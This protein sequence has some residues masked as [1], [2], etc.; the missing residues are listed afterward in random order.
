M[1]NS[2]RSLIIPLGAVAI[3]IALSACPW[4]RWSGGRLKD[5]H[6]F[7]DLMPQKMNADAERSNAADNV[8]PELLK[9]VEQGDSAEA[10][11]TVIEAETATA[12]V[13]IVPDVAPR[14][15]DVVLIEDYS[16]DGSALHKLKNTLAQ[17][18]I[19]PVRIAMVGDS[20]IEGDILAQD[21]RAGLQ[22]QYGGRGVGYVAAFSNFPGFRGSVNQSAKG[23]KETE[24]RKMNND[25]LR[26]ILG[27]YHTADAGAVSSF[28][29]SKRPDHLD[30][31][32]SSTMIYQ[33]SNP[34]SVTITVADS[35]MTFPIAASTRLQAIA[36]PGAT[37]EFKVEINSPGLDVLGIWLENSTGIVLD[38]ISLRGN[39]GI[40]HRQLDASTTREMR[41]WIDYD[42]IIL[43]FGMNA[44]SAAQKDYTPY[45]RGMEEVI[46][47]LR[48]LYPNAQIL[49]MGVAD[50]GAKQGTSLGSMPTVAALVKAQRAMAARSGV[51][52][53]DTR[54][55][56]GGE[57]AAV[58]WHN[59]RLVNSDYVHLNHKGGK[60]LADIFLES[61]NHSIK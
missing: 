22:S 25:P 20:Y 8:D 35:A 19:R 34:G 36:V 41:N 24:I 46:A 21:I 11:D 45:A 33:A 14:D 16:A 43:E 48:S 7:A 30:S 31:W 15:G 26:T 32:N 56:M 58:D 10:V 12:P 44:L 57:G 37:S 52:F 28:K 3:L 47:N 60:A 18:I 40:S 5:F 27:L 61:L 2:L 17:A 39:S 38:D 53:Y 13:I 1:K 4:E 42:L 49:V 50:R 55:A 51:L 23:W 59:R 6:L 9:F 54:A 29:G